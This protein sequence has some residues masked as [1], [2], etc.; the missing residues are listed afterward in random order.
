MI[1]GDKSDGQKIVDWCQQT[2]TNITQF[3]FKGVCSLFLRGKGKSLYWL[4]AVTG[5]LPRTSS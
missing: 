4:D 2:G 1:G 3:G 5:A